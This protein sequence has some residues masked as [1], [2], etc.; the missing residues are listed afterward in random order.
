[1]S[2]EIPLTRG[3]VAIV[4][5]ED[6]ERVAAF[7]WQARLR[8]GKP[9]Y[10]IRTDY[11]LGRRNKR[12]ISMH[13]FILGLG[14]KDAVLADHVDGDGLN[15][16]RANLRMATMSE[17]ARNKK[18]RSDNKSGIKGVSYRFGSWY[19][20]IMCD[21]RRYY[22]GAYPTAQL[23]SAAYDAAAIRFFGAYARTNAQMGLGRA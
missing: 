5:D 8:V 6:Y 3:Y 23:A 7:K 18:R 15:N 19:A 13:R 14:H 4:D 2:R 21:R 22:L 12:T 9:A 20:E 10:A 1:M 17:N 11:G 16:V